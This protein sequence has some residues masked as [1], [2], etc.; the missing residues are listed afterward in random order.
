[1]KKEKKDNIFVGTIF[2]LLSVL[3]LGLVLFSYIFGAGDNSFMDTK[4]WIYYF[5][6]SLLHGGLFIL[7][8]FALVY[9]PLSL[10]GVKRKISIPILSFFYIFVTLVFVINRFVFQIYHFHINGFVLDMLFSEGAGEIFVFSVWLYIKAFLILACVCLA[11]FFLYR[12][13]VYLSKKVRSRKLYSCSLVS[14]LVV[15][16]ISQGLHIY[17]AARLET[18][19]L[20]SDTYLPYYFPISMNSALDKMGIIDKKQI[21]NI[22]FKDNKAPISYPLHQLTKDG[23]H[24]S[25]PNIVVIAID[26]W[27]FRTLSKEC[28]PNI[29]KFKEQA[30]FFQN[31]LSSSNGTR[32]GIFGLFTGLSS[33]YWK[34][35]EYSSLKPV[36]I[37]Q[38]QKN[39]YD[40]QVY[41][42]ATFKSP[43]FDR[44]FFKGIDIN[45]S[46]KGKTAYERD[47][48]I[49]SN[50]I[51]DLKKHKKENNKPFFS[52]LFYDMAHAI[53]IPK[54]RNSRFLP[55]WDYA[56]YSTLTNSTDPLPFYNLY[57]NCVYQI[58][59]LLGM[60]LNSLKENQLLDNTIVLITGDHGQEFNENKKNYWGHSGNYS[61]YQIQVPLIL[62]YPKVEYKTFAYRT[63]HYD[64]VPTLL[65]M[66]LGINNPPKDYSMG[67]LLHN[68]SSR[69]WH[70]VGNDL[71]YAFITEDG[72]IIEK[73]GNGY[74]KVYDKNLNI[75]RNY[76]LSPKEINDNLLKLNR[77]FK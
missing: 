62:Y 59:S 25:K 45:S 52:F 70:V 66:A 76:K 26:S 17:G 67:E 30:E 47:C 33:Y 11:F 31:H 18:S 5:F 65:N 13:S 64:I 74:V 71:N 24:S 14:F 49:T 6:S 3:L 20:E 48:N 21:T 40:I 28:M 12:L 29:W 7:V 55:A 4:A 23:L 27:N 75:Q 42:S 41:P 63:T 60:V 37:D 8:P 57:R 32:G 36:F 34:S 9:I 16:L 56:D 50:F 53:S 22:K 69:G 46:T 72:Y 51:Y 2:T 35:F 10:C 61:K 1:M 73:E 15:I 44:M 54:E 68:S 39:N 38:L 58:D 43:P 77:F 19:I